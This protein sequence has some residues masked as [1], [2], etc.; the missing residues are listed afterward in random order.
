M[1]WLSTLRTQPKG[2]DQQVEHLQVSV[3]EAYL[4]VQQLLKRS[5]DSWSMTLSLWIIMCTA[6]ALFAFIA[7]LV[8]HGQDKDTCALI[9]I[10]NFLVG[11]IPIAILTHANGFM[12]R[13]AKTISHS[14]PSDF[15]CIG[16][17][18]EWIDFIDK[19]PAYWYILGFAITRSWLITFF[20]AG[21]STSFVMM[22]DKF[23][24]LK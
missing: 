13:L 19:N 20:S 11:I 4:M 10:F 5:T 3:G 1:R 2:T 6:F 14:K 12:D 21:L 22:F 15:Q 9:A 17:R 8:L 7:S 16:G 23:V 24:G 18:Q